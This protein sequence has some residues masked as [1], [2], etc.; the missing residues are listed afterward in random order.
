MSSTYFTSD[1]FKTENINPYPAGTKSDKPLSP[2]YSQSSLFVFIIH[3]EYSGE[4][5]LFQGNKLKLKSDIF[6][7]A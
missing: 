6:D 7:L 5:V 1:L 4:I 2:V 3:S